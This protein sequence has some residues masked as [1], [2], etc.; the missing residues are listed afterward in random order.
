MKFLINTIKTIILKLNLGGTMAIYTPSHTKLSVLISYAHFLHFT[1]AGLALHL[2]SLYMLRV[3][4]VNVVR[5]VMNSCPFN[6]FCLV[7]IPYFRDGRII[8]GILVQF[9]YFRRAIN[10]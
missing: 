6:R 5:K 7:W 1:V 3:V 2:T 10:F 8:A 9:F 4:E